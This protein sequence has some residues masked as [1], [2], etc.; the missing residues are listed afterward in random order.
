MHSKILFAAAAAGSLV[1]GAAYAQRTYPPHVDMPIGAQIGAVQPGGAEVG[2]TVAD[3]AAPEVVVAATP[4]QANAAATTPEPVRLGQSTSPELVTN[5][6]VR[7]T[8]ATR[9][10]YP[11]L[12]RAGKLTA[13][14]GN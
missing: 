8:P 6:P 5:G 12:S 1:A 9:R 11:P 7:D 3:K 13:P 4:S 10:L 14:A 2:E